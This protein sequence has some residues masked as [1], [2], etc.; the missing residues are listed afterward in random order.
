MWKKGMHGMCKD[1]GGHG[2]RVEMGLIMDGELMG[3]FSLQNATI[4]AACSRP[5]FHEAGVQR[6]GPQE[7][8]TARRETHGSHTRLLC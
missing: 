5:G 4:L 1:V 7:G 3:N 6:A 2:D 8:S